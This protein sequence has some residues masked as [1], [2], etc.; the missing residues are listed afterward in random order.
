M[1]SHCSPRPTDWRQSPDRDLNDR[2]VGMTLFEVLLVLVLLV[3]MASLA[4]PILK[5]TLAT[6]RLRRGTDKVLAVWSQVRTR[7]IEEGHVY[8]FRFAE[9]GNQYRVDRWYPDEDYE[10]SRQAPSADEPVQLSDLADPAEDSEETEWRLED[11]IHE[12]VEFVSGQQA[13]VNSDGE[14]EVKTL[15]DKESE[16]WS[17]PILFFPDGTTS[18]ASILLRN[19]NDR[20]QR[21]T[22]R[23]LTGAARGSKLLSATE[24]EEQESR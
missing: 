2:R 3:V 19:E 24:I 22:L 15:E 5:G 12:T 8:Q 16:D 1:S 4:M 13:Q 21:A 9:K 20:Y 17:A 10:P 11:S 14:R 23:A 18:E 7:A 6:V